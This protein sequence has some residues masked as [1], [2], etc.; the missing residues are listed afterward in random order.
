MADEYTKEWLDNESGGT[1]VDA[2]ALNDFEARAEARVAA[3]ALLA[4]DDV[5]LW[6]RTGVLTTD[7]VGGVAAQDVPIANL[8]AIL[9][10]S[11]RGAVMRPER[12]ET[13]A[14]RIILPENRAIAIEGVGSG[15]RSS[16][17]VGSRIKRHAAGGAADSLVSCIGSGLTDSTRALGRLARLMLHGGRDS[18]FMGQ[19]P[20]VGFNRLQQVVLEDLY[21]F[22]NDGYGLALSQ[23]FNSHLNEINVT[24][25]GSPTLDAFG[26]VQS[27]IQVSGANDGG[28][29]RFLA[30]N[31]HVEQ[32]F[33]T[34]VRLGLPSDTDSY[35]TEFVINGLSMEGGLDSSGVPNPIPYPYLHL[36]FA[37]SGEINGLH[38]FSHRSVPS[39]LSEHPA[40]GGAGADD[41]V[42]IGGP[43]ITQSPTTPNPDYFVEVTGG[44]VHFTP[45]FKIR[46]KPNIAYIHI[47][48]NVRPGAVKF[49]G[50][51][52][53]R[54]GST[55]PRLA[56]DERP[57]PEFREPV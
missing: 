45:G 18:G 42:V 55:P 17:G 3:K 33:C 27:A 13:R 21:L 49:H 8:I 43:G 51:T 48:P 5:F 7:K 35:V 37:E 23:V 40:G 32:S 9:Q 11:A 19:A 31:W 46:G 16:G 12:G 6:K 1:P 29:V 53:P 41:A 22:Q 52:I 30:N 54:D 34:D 57:I 36:G 56:V 26:H 25:C 14:N 38:I 15:W 24:H 28:T 4:N 39:I 2:E 10:A 50:A 20:L 47:G 44:A